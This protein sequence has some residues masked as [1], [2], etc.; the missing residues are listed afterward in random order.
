DF[1]QSIHFELTDFDLQEHRVRVDAASAP[2][3]ISYGISGRYGY[4]ALDY[5]SF[6]QEA[7]GTPWIAFAEGQA[8][9]T[10]LYYT[11]PGRDFLRR[12]F[13]PGRDAINHAV[14]ARQLAAL[15]SADRIASVGY[16]FDSEDTVSSGPMGRD[17]QY[18]GH[19]IDLGLVVPM[20]PFVRL[21]LGYLFR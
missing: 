17:F 9:A 10:Q 14:G 2:G 15:G 7:L 8:A 12:P 11:V 19:Q 3:T 4:D 1:Y 13:D 21:D 16:Q 20:P 18:K 5:R 6:F